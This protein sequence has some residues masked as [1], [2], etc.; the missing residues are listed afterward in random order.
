MAPPPATT[1]PA[2]TAQPGGGGMAFLNAILKRTDMLLALGLIGILSVLILPMPPWL[3]DIGLALSFSLSVL[4]L[5]VALFIERPLDF[6]SFPTLLLITTMLRLALNMASTRLI[7]G[8]GH[9]GTDAAG[10]VI[11]AFGNFLMQGNTVIGIIVFIILVIVNFVVIT[12]GSGRIAEVSARFSLDSMPG[13]QMAIDA[14]LSAGL[15]NEDEARRRRKDLEAETTF[16]GSMDGAAKFV[17]GDAVA[18]LLIT[19][20]N[21]I[22]GIIIGTVMMDMELKEAGYTY[23]FLTIGDGLVAQIPALIVS[24]A[25]GILVTKSGDRGSADKALVKQLGGYPGALGLAAGLMGAFAL[26]PGIPFMPFFAMAAIAGTGAWATS[27]QNKRLAAAVAAEKLPTPQQKADQQAAAEEPIANVLRIDAVRLELGYGLLPLIRGERGAALPE[28]IKALRRQLAGEIG[29]VVPSVR[30]QDNM[31]LQADTYSIR[32]KEIETGKGQVKSD[33]LLVMNPQGAD[34]QMK[35]E[36]TVEPTFGLPAQWI[37]D[38]QREEANFKGYTV[39]EPATV[40]MTHLTE[41]IKDNMADLLSYAETQKLLDQLGEEH[42]KLV[43]DVVPDQISVGGLQRVLQSLLRERV[44]I[45]DLPTILEGVAEAGA[46]SRNL[47]LITEHV[48]MR[49]ARY[50]SEGAMGDDGTIRL[51]TLSPEWEQAFN[52]ALVGQG[53]DKHLAIAP[54]K[55]QQFMAK[56]RTTFERHAAM[57]EFPVLLT[58]PGLRPYVR[59]LIERFRP[60]TP[61]LSQNEIHPKARIKTVGQL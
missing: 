26:L 1:P 35:G 20:I 7:L 50:I 33:K 54:S 45:R 4:V 25:A 24:V 44:S 27:R 23:T 10:H 47:V 2:T 40:L 53:E 61:V 17:R 30:I 12:K 22:G 11:E 43:A 14:D 8:H 58:S 18:G 51:V 16:F 57:G 52:D 21:V 41:I 39:V 46:Q 19:V 29:F 13:K 48:R 5:M 42:K 36:P 38:S 56:V 31:Q 55:L 34:I 37:T 3:L 15:I 6:S 59:S 49:L 60:S 28:Q 32:I 9:E